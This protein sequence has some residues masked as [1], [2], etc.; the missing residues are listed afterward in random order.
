MEFLY[1]S[2]ISL[3]YRK[4]SDV[5]GELNLFTSLIPTAMEYIH[6]NVKEIIYTPDMLSVIIACY[7]IQ[8]IKVRLFL[9]R[10]SPNMDWIDC[11]ESIARFSNWFTLSCR[12]FVLY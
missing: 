1:A 11:I 10:F 9:L 5:Q 12:T 4:V 2:I 3:I 8:E 7:N 6:G